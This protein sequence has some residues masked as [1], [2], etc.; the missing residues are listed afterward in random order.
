MRWNKVR[1]LCN[2]Q[3]YFY[4]SILDFMRKMHIRVN[5]LFRFRVQ[6]YSQTIMRSIKRSIVTETIDKWLKLV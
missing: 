4:I 6:I 5:I 3:S 1:N 2:S